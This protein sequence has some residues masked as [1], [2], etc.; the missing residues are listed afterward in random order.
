MPQL[1]SLQWQAAGG[2]LWATLRPGDSSYF[3]AGVPHAIRNRWE[4]RGY[5][6][7]QI[8]PPQF[9]LFTDAGT[10]NPTRAVVNGQA[11]R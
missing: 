3:P 8:C 5:L 11:V 10:Y 1:P 4:G 6:V 9:D 2:L 7:T